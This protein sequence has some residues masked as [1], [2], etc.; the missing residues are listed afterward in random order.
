MK[1]ANP[2]TS[3]WDILTLTFLDS[4]FVFLLECLNHIILDHPEYN[5]FISAVCLSGKTTSSKHVI[6]SELS[7]E[8]L[9]SN[10][11]AIFSK[12]FQIL[13]RPRKFR[14]PKS[15]AYTDTWNKSENIFGY[16]N[17]AIFV[18]MYSNYALGHNFWHLNADNY[19]R[20]VVFIESHLFPLT[21]STNDSVKRKGIHWSFLLVF[22]VERSQCD[23]LHSA[24]QPSLKN[25]HLLEG[26]DFQWFFQLQ[27]QISRFQLFSTTVCL[28]TI[29]KYHSFSPL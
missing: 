12:K 22:L 10:W 1:L 21:S 29:K 8:D 19:I 15:R 4:P 9:M 27:L 28:I 20:K 25:P 3:R 26:L 14:S 17:T 2:V 18:K 6:I 23:V 24:F 16:K 5:K 7:D 13:Q 11:M